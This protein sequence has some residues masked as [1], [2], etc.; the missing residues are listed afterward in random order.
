MSVLRC[1]IVL[2]NFR[3]I[4]CHLQ[5]PMC[6]G[7]FAQSSLHALVPICTGQE[8]QQHDP[9]CA[10]APSRLHLP[11]LTHVL[12]VHVPLEGIL[13]VPVATRQK[14]VLLAANKSFMCI[15]PMLLRGVQ[16]DVPDEP[17]ACYPSRCLAARHHRRPWQQSREVHGVGS[18]IINVHILRSDSAARGEASRAANKPEL[19]TITAYGGRTTHILTTHRRL[20]VSSVSAHHG[21]GRTMSMPRTKGMAGGKNE[22]ARADATTAA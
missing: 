14:C 1:C 19:C 5:P 13:Q 18:V 15:E 7:D 17:M 8:K 3:S 6:K 21:A 2:H 10:W 16:Q 4:W 9:C 22:E 11:R 20:N 12:T